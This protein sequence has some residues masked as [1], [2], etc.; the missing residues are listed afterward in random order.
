MGIKIITKNKRASYDFELTERYEA[1]LVLQGTEVKS[2]R[3]GKV[4]I[5]EAHISIDKNS[6]VW[7]YNMYIGHYE[8]GSYNNHEEFRK[9]KLLLNAKEIKELERAVSAKG[10]TIVPT[11]LYFKKS[12][13]KIEIALA[14]GKKL[15]DKRQDKAKKDVERKLRQKDYN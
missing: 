6:E 13:V 5:A 2:I 7:L 10:L 12:R 9:R 4:K 11:I 1:G 14:K 15:Y 3:D 8:Q